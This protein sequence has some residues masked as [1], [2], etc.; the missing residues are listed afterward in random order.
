MT[1]VD[2][3]PVA[4]EI[5]DAIADQDLLERDRRRK[6]EADL[7]DVLIAG[8]LLGSALRRPAPREIAVQGVAAY[9]VLALS[10]QDCTAILSRAEHHLTSLQE[11]LGC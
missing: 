1:T 6:H 3:S 11:T 10:S 9:S 5:C 2:R 7:T 8:V 4:R